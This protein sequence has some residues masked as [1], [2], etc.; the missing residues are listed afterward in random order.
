MRTL[1]LRT[2]NSARSLMAEALFNTLAKG[3]FRGMS[4]VVLNQTVHENRDTSMLNMVR[5]IGTWATAKAAPC[6]VD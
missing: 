2:G 6:E 3:R 5:A 1:V 4:G